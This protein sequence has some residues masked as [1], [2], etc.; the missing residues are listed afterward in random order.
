MNF[1]T[2][3]AWLVASSSVVL[4]WHSSDDLAQLICPMRLVSSG[5]LLV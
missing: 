5:C 3:E 2:K 4:R 1:F